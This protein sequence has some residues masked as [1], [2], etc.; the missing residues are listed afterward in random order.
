M[1]TTSQHA[2]ILDRVFVAPVANIWRCWAESELFSQWFLPAPWRVS[3]AKVDL[4]NGG[5]LSC[6]MNGP[7]GERP[8][9][10]GVFLDVLREKRIVHTNVFR[11][12]WMPSGQAFMVVHINLE[13]AEGNKTHYVV[14]AM[15]WNAETKEEHEKKGLYTNWNKASDQMEAL[16][17]SLTDSNPVSS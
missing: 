9:Y 10:T 6:V 3:D 12:G 1:T 8:E 15:Y 11:Q 2:L 13:E 14:E 5:E 7:N 17:K 4:R 16:A